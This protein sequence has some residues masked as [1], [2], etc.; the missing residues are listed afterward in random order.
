MNGY[1]GNHHVV[2]ASVHNPLLEVATKFQDRRSGYDLSANALCECMDNGLVSALSRIVKVQLM[3]IALGWNSDGRL[4]YVLHRRLRNSRNKFEADARR[5]VIP[6]LAVVRDEV[7]IRDPFAE[8]RIRPLRQIRRLLIRVR[9]D[10]VSVDAIEVVLFGEGGKIIL[11]W[12]LDQPSFEPDFVFAAALMDVVAEDRDHQVEEVFVLA[13]H[14]VR[15]GSIERESL[16]ANR[17]AQS[18]DAR[19]LLEDFHVFVEV[20][21]ERDSGDA[22]AKNPDQAV[23]RAATA[24]DCDA[25]RNPWPICATTFVPSGSMV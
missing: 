17:S 8:G 23:S 14:D 10:D 22:A 5:V 4:E 19:P 7:L 2:L 6:D 21:S 16:I 24:S 3:Q 1:R 11:K 25:E 20:G 9:I 13:E 12:I 18:A 15:A